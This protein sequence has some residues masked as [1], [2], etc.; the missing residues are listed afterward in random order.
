VLDLEPSIAAE[1][2]VVCESAEYVEH[3]GLRQW[4]HYEVL[5]AYLGPGSVVIAIIVWA[6]FQTA[7][8]TLRRSAVHQYLSRRESQR[9]AQPAPAPAEPTRV[10][11]KP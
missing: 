2:I 9:A 4:L 1:L 6:A 3:S 11:T 8:P 7:V 10:R 5:A